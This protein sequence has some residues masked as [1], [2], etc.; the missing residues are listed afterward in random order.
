MKKTAITLAAVALGVMLA[1]PAAAQYEK[2]L[3]LS[4]RLGLFFPTNGD[5]RD[6]E[7]RSWFAG[8]LEYKIRDLNYGSSNQMSASLTI[9]ADY[10]GKGDF[11]NIPLQLN[12]VARSQQVYYGAG[13]GVGFTH[14]KGGRNQDSNDVD[15]T[16]NLV[17][18]YDFV[19]SSTPFFIEGRYWG[20]N[21]SQLNGFGVYAGVRF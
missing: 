9:S 17:V 12:W 15:F 21:E 5:A 19:R 3:G 16:F 20:S 18:G 11:S 13:A 14:I 6:E 8:G 1:A 7:G 10:Y 4:A 2:P